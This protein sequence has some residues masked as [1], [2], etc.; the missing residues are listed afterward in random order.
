MSGSSFLPPLSKEEFFA[1]NPSSQTFVGTSR[2][3]W[4]HYRLWFFF[5]L[6]NEIPEHWN[7]RIRKPNFH[8]MK[9]WKTEMTARDKAHQ[10]FWRQQC[11]RERRYTQNENLN[12]AYAK[13]GK[14]KLCPRRAHLESKFIFRSGFRALRNEIKFFFAL[15]SWTKKMKMF[16]TLRILGNHHHFFC[17][18]SVQRECKI[19]SFS[20]LRVL[21]KQSKWY[22]RCT[23]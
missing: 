11:L 1:G 13:R 10:T 5:K 6:S 16:S 12:P 20:I 22:R 15:R 17:L 19:N 14:S 4:S 8:Y 23:H 7:A 9:F 21:R 18:H 2:N 3:V